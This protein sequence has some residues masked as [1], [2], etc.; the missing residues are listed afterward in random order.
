MR[1]YD[2]P[3]HFLRMIESGRLLETS[4]CRERA[5]LFFLASPE[6]PSGRISASSASEITTSTIMSPATNSRPGT[7]I[8]LGVCF[9]GVHE[10]IGSHPRAL[11]ERGPPKSGSISG[12]QTMY[13]AFDAWVLY[14]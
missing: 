6:R 8:R 10:P 4:C 7:E 12:V 14:R 3:Q 5:S 1:A 2:T 11:C 9:L 13:P